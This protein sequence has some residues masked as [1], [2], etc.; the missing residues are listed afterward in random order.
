M[1]LTAQ[2]KI[3]TFAKSGDEMW[4]DEWRSP[5]QV[6]LPVGNPDDFLQN[7]WR[8][9]ESPTGAVYVDKLESGF[10][11]WTDTVKAYRKV[12]PGP[13]AFTWDAP[14]QP[15]LEA[16]RAVMTRDN[17]FEQ[18]VALL[19]QESAKNPTTLKL[20]PEIVA[21]IKSIGMC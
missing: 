5:L 13:S 15:A 9:G 10:L 2:V 7:L 17:F 11:T 18:L 6:E 12:G 16:I 1:K 19:A 20:R 4:R 21:L 3:R 8:S 14:S